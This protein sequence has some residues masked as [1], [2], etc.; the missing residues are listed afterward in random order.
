MSTLEVTVKTV[1][2]SSEPKHID[3]VVEIAAGQ[4]GCAEK[5]RATV[6]TDN[7]TVRRTVVY[8]SIVEPA[9]GVCADKTTADVV[10]E[11]PALA[12]AKLVMNNQAWALGADGATYTRCEGSFG[13]EPPPAD[14]CDEAWIDFLLSNVELAPD[15]DV[16]VLGCDGTWVVLDID[17]APSGCE[18][19]D[20]RPVPSG[21]T[22]SHKRWFLTFVDKQTGWDVVAAGTSAGCTD[23]HATVPTFPS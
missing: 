15:R 4:D 22:Y 13:C 14:H 23:V 21:C 16:D 19:D 17:T 9:Y 20:G 6:Q 12:P 5:P 18:S 3:M 11:L 8:D 7:D 10:A 1:S 2:V